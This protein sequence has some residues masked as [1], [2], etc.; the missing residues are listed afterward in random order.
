MLARL[1]DG[2]ANS[3]RPWAL[4]LANV[5][6]LVNI[7]ARSIGADSRRGKA[8]AGD[9]KARRM[10]G[11]VTAGSRRPQPAHVAGQPA[12]L[13]RNTAWQSLSR[14]LG[15]VLS[16]A[17]APVVISGLG[18]TKFGVWA[19]TGALAQYAAL[20]DL[21]AGVSLARYIAAHQDD[22]RRCGQYIAISAA[23]VA[24]V[25]AA[26]AT[27]AVVLAEPLSR[28]VG[29]IGGHDM[30]V[31][32]VA[33]VSL[34][35]CSMLTSVITAAPIG[36]RRMVA[37]NVG[38]CIGAVVNF[39]ASVGSIAL[40][41]GLTGYA[42]ANA[43]AGLLSVLVI[44]AIVRRAE[45]PLPW[46][47]PSSGQVRD[48]LAYS[49]KNQVV[50]LMDL[51]NYQTDKIVIAFTVGPSTAGAYELANRV[52]VAVRQIGVYAT[53][54]IDI[55]MT[56]VLRDRGL[57]AVRARYRR[58]NEVAAVI[59]FPGVLLV[60]ALAPLLLRAWLAEPPPDSE[61]VLLAL[62]AAYLTAGS[63]G[64]SYGVAVAAGEPG[65]VAKTAMATAV[66]NL[67]LTAGLAPLFGIW[68]VLSGTVVALTGGALGQVMFV[69]RRYDLTHASYLDA[70]STPLLR[71]FL[72]ALPV[73]A[74]SYGGVIHGRAAAA[75]AVVAL[76][77]GYV[78]TCLRWAWRSDRLPAAVAQRVARLS[79]AGASG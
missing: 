42:L 74:V 4:R 18:L 24:V 36:N 3:S 71:Y 45:G 51:V 57:P 79:R 52:A 65:I 39:I 78:L 35:G 29:S 59:A 23:V 73:A 19:L 25:V 54:A 60:M 9:L 7:G 12:S 40:G 28:A 38:A 32:L 61:L 14:L 15:Y 20:I 68:G 63:T 46:A 72:Y 53:S 67:A 22:E 6:R 69:H 1:R 2:P 75:V 21:G 50:R 70:I 33:S 66:V 77:V 8:V 11:R 41:A 43:G 5:R 48:F 37:P 64:V 58:F 27:V 17:S 31:V 55:E 10:P 13:A 34:V 47:R 16:F 49:T 26:L 30:R 62:C 56:A 44:A 76:T